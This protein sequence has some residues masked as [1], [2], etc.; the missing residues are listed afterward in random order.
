MFFIEGIIFSAI[1]SDLVLTAL[2]FVRPAL[3]RALGC[4]LAP[5]PGL[6]GLYP[7]SPGRLWGFCSVP[8]VGMISPI[9]FF[10]F[11]LG[12]LPRLRP[13]VPLPLGIIDSFY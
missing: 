3:L 11:F 2:V 13:Y 6:L 12:G 10:F 9:Y 7:G 4:G 5:L 8:C 1:M